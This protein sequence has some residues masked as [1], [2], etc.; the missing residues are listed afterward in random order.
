MALPIILYVKPH[1]GFWESIMKEQDDL[2]KESPS[3]QVL[4]KKS[5]DVAV[6]IA[7]QTNLSGQNLLDLLK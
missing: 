7:G 5:D 4:I 6:S 3:E 2:L 1:K